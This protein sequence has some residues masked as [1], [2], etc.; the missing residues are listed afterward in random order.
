MGGTS[1]CGLYNRWLVFP[2]ILLA[3]LPVL[4]VHSL[5]SASVDI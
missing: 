3:I 4:I 1:W 2:V 5:D